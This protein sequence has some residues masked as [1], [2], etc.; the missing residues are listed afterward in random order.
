MLDRHGCKSQ[1]CHL[2]A[3]LSWKGNFTTII[4]FSH[5]YLSKHLAQSINFV[6]MIMK[7]LIR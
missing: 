2:M 1:L 3:Q 4:L 7:L 5:L 6:V